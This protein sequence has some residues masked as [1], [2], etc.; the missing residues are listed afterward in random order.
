M[1]K[2]LD[3]TKSKKI[4]AQ[5]HIPGSKSI[6]NRALILQAFLPYLKIKNLPSAEDTRVLQEALTSKKENIDIGHAGTAMRFLTAYYAIQPGKKVCL[7]GSQRMLERPVKILVDALQ[8]LGAKIEYI[9]KT[10][11]PPLQIYGQDIKQNK[12]QIQANVSSQYI[13]A[14]LLIAPFLKKGL[15]IELLGKLTSKPYIDMTLNLLQQV[16]VKTPVQNNIIKISN[17]IKITFGIKTP[18]LKP[19]SI[20]IEPDWSSASYFY[21]LVALH[22]NAQIHLEGFKTDSLQGDSIL[23]ELYKELGVKSEFTETGLNLSKQKF[24]QKELLHYDLVNNPDL[25]QTIAVS[26]LGLGQDC[27]LTGLHTLK[28]KETNRLQALKNELEKF[29]AVVKISDNSLLL[30]PPK[31]L[32]ANTTIASYQDHRMAMAFAPLSV[33]TPIEIQNA[34][35][36]RKSYPRFW[37]DF[38]EIL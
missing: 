28:I 29:G 24:E 5:I 23:P 2:A 16:G 32:P 6:A 7:T 4:R 17:L 22:P 36:V 37:K 13:S 27:H 14:L 9:N 34:E 30:T 3:F 38:E 35:V 25:A 12:V 19:L 33:L 31:N 20:H 15:E 21:S 8:E 26:C 18:D 10:G 1:T 11:Y